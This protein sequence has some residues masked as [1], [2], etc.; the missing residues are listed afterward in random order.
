[1]IKPYVILTYAGTIP[2]L[3]CAFLLLLDMP[4]SHQS[5]PIESILNSYSFVIAAFMIGSHWGQHLHLQTRY[6]VTLQFSS[7]IMALAVWM[8]FMVFETS[9]LL[10]IYIFIFLILL[11][12]DY[13]LYQLKINS[14]DYFIT[15]FG[16]TSLVIFSLTLAG[17]VL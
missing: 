10:L 2:F 17:I 15:R 6:R 16:A 7:I 9:L 1:M 12:I 8:S 5:L 3:I 14:R 4:Q 11:A 13:K